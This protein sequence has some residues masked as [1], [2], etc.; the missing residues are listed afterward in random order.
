MIRFTNFLFAPGDRPDRIEKA[1]TTDADIVCVDLE[2]SVAAAAKAAARATAVDLLGRLD[3]DRMALRINALDTLEGLRDLTLLAESATLPCALFLPM[4]EN[5][6][7]PAQVARVLG[8]RCPPLVPLIETVAGLRAADAIAAAPRVGAMMFGGGDFSAQLGVKLEWTP[9]LAARSAFVMSC[10]GAQIPAIDVPFIR[11]DDEDGL[12]AECLAAK[13]LGFRVKAA[14]HPRQIAPIG[15]VLRPT[16]EEVSEAQEAVAAFEAGGGKAIAFRGRML[17]A[18][19]MQRYYRI[20]SSAQ[21]KPGRRE[22]DGSQV[23]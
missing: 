6:A 23:K 20:M 4:V 5:A 1:L 15:A 22:G 2:D 16:A 17:E 8:D 10:A 18:P 12:R 3:A 11:L 9:L 21:I 14:I 13:E 7:T 19:V